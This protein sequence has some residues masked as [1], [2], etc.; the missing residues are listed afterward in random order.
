MV[1]LPENYCKI[2]NMSLALAT[3]VMFL[4]TVCMVGYI[5]DASA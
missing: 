5:V 4:L 3:S 1:Q 2:S